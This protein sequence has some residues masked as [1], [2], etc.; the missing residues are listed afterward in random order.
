[1]ADRRLVRW[2]IVT[3]VAS[4]LLLVVG[5]VVRVTGSGMGCPD[6]PY[7][8]GAALPPGQL[9]PEQHLPAWIEMAHR[10]L[11]G[12]VSLLVVVTAGLAWRRRA[13]GA[14]WRWAVA[15]IAVIV[16]QILLGAVTVWQSNAPWTVSAHLMAALALVGVTVVTAL[17]AARPGALGRPGPAAWTLVA[18]TLTLLF[19]GSI[20]QTTG[21]GFACP[22]PVRCRGFWWPTALGL[23]AQVHMLHRLLAVLTG[24]ALAAVAWPAWRSAGDA[25]RRWAVAAALLYVAQI[26]VGVAQVMLTMPPVLRGTHLAV[27]AAFWVAVV[28]LVVRGAQATAAVADRAAAQ[29]TGLAAARSSS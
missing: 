19:V 13:A 16:V 2:A 4:W 14:P 10:Y 24:V 25:Q 23:P 6:W 18:L 11:A 20:V 26:A 5:G 7:C 9:A 15:G 22:D 17:L 27:A 12:I 3:A 28:G 8:F 1:M 21:G 29:P